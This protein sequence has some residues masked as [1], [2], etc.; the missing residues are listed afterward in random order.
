MV[1]FNKEGERDWTERRYSDRRKIQYQIVFTDRRKK[2][3]RSGFDRRGLSKL[4]F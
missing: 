3:R 2:A 4:K 1:D